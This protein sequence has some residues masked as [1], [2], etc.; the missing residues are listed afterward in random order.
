MWDPDVQ[1]SVWIRKRVWICLSNKT[2]VIYGFPPQTD[3]L[4]KNDWMIWY[5]VNVHQYLPIVPTVP[6][7]FSK[8]KNRCLYSIW[9]LS[10]FIDIQDKYWSLFC[11]NFYISTPN[12]F[13]VNRTLCI[14]KTELLDDINLYTAVC[15]QCICVRRSMDSLKLTD[16]VRVRY[17]ASMD[18]L[19]GGLNPLPLCNGPYTY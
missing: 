13:F 12:Q 7:D 16:C 18:P 8:V 10:V 17:G 19:S 6:R 14:E 5:S 9:T 1:Y 3:N 4:E 11:Y 2:C 15:C